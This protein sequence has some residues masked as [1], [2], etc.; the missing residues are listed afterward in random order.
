MNVC[1][2]KHVYKNEYFIIRKENLQNS[3]L[4]TANLHQYLNP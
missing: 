2:L 1:S 4:E 3:Y